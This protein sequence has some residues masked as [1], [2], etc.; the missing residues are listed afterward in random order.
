MAAEVNGKLPEED[1]F[2]TSETFKLW[3]NS[4]IFRQSD[5]DEMF[6]V[7][8]EIFSMHISMTINQK[9]KNNGKVWIS[10]RC[11]TRKENNLH[12]RLCDSK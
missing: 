4:V 9:S 5:S 12:F 2:D 8:T 10:K 11:E 7:F 6:T 1:F 3:M